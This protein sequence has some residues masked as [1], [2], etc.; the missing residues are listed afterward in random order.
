MLSL[1]VLTGLFTLLSTALAADNNSLR[2][3]RIYQLV[4]DRFATSTNSTTQACNVAAAP[5]CGGSYQGIINQLGYVS[6]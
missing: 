5:Y 6:L 2:Q 1:P 4:T 3:R